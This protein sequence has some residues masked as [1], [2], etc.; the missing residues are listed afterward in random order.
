MALWQEKG[1]GWR[2]EFQYQ[3]KRCVGA[4]FKSQGEARAAM[5]AKRQEVKQEPKPPE[6]TYSTIANLY[7]D[8]AE[9]KFAAKTYKYKRYVLGSFLAHAGDIPVDRI[10]VPLIESYLSTRKTNTNY[11]RHRKDL[12][13]L[14]TWAWRRGLMADNPCL[15]LEKMPEPKFARKIPT[16]EEM[17]A[18]M[19]AAG[20]HRPF[21]L[22]LYHTLGRM[23]EILRLRWEDVSFRNRTVRLWT[24]KRKD[25]AWESDFIH[26]NDVLYEVLEDLYKDRGYNEYVFTNTKTGNRYNNWRRIMQRICDR[27]GVPYYKFHDIRH[28]VASLLHDQEHVSLPKVSKLLRHKSKRTTELYL[29]VIDP[30]LREVMAKLER[31]NRKKKDEDVGL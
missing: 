22:V 14:F 4:G 20:E 19:L 8:Q 13:A 30:E 25:G 17:A 1:K 2:F 21:L 12:C 7:L 3:G 31:K 24:Q 27:A 29:Q 6:T 23:G 15:W 9:R 10:T 11:N 16:P 5:E 18:I 28:Y 26:M